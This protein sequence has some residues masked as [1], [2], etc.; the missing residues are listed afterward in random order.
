[1]PEG[2]PPRQSLTSET[3][4][5]VRGRYTPPR[6]PVPDPVIFLA[7]HG[8]CELEHFAQSA[9][10]SCLGLK[11]PFS[12]SVQPRSISSVANAPSRSFSSRSLVFPPACK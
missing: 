11:A 8:H 7:S 10:F 3:A 1:M 9:D 12:L 6:L 4:A 5:Q 2:L